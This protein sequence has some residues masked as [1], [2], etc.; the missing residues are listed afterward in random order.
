MKIPAPDFLVCA[1]CTQPDELGERL[2]P[3]GLHPHPRPDTDLF[4]LN[5]I[6]VFENKKFEFRLNIFCK[7]K[8]EE[9]WPDVRLAEREGRRDG[10][11]DVHI[12]AIS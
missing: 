10:G 11:A 8:K 12:R 9:V 3:H 4:F 1:R 5:L 7:V 2:G 6:F